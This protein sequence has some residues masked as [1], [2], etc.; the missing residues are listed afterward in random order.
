MNVILINTPTK[1][2]RFRNPLM[3]GQEPLNVAYLASVLINNNH[4]VIIKDF[5]VEGYN[6]NKLIKL[7]KKFCC[8]IVGISCTTP[9]FST[10]NKIIKDLRKELNPTIILGGKHPSSMPQKT[11][12]ESQADFVVCGEGEEI[13]P[14]LI[15]AIQ[16]NKSYS[17]IPGITYKEAGRIIVNPPQ[18]PT[19]DLDSIPFPA[20]DLLYSNRYRSFSTGKKFSNILSS[21]G[22]PFSCTYCY[23]SKNNPAFKRIRFRSIDNIVQEIKL[24]NDKYGINEFQ[25]VDDNFTINP[26]RVIQFCNVIEQNNLKIKFIVQGRVNSADL[27]MYKKLKEAGCELIAFGIESGDDGILQDI[28]K[29]IT[30]AQIEKAVKIAKESGINVRG[31]FIIGFPNDTPETIT[32]T[33]KLAKKLKLFR[34]SFFMLTPYPHSSLWEEIV[35][36]GIINTEKVNWNKFDQQHYYFT[37]KNLTEKALNHYLDFGRVYSSTK[38]KQTIGDFLSSNNKKNFLK[39]WIAVKFGYYEAL[40][41]SK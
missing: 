27:E 38:L 28:K 14:E 6:K 37:N 35:E 26:K 25:F 10:T 9:T 24:L 19:D 32:K 36:R 3:F 1:L 33:I 5:N 20:R 12:E 7:C 21:R 41:P 17:G 40:K 8:D 11:M 13:L 39:N 29:Q 16:K 31:N 34:A 18:K 2:Q 30:V 4:K 22:C 15:D 23:N